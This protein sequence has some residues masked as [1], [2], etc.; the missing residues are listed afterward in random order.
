MPK[1]KH[2]ILGWARENSLL[3]IEEAA[4]KLKIKDDKKLYAVEKLSAYESGEEEPSRSLLLRM[5]RQYRQPLLVFYL[6][7]PPIIGDRGEDF[8]TLPDQFDET[9]NVNVD[10][11]IRD[12]K[13]RQSTIRETLIEADEEIKLGFIGRNKIVDGVKLVVQT[14][15]TTLNVELDDFRNQP[16]YKEAF[17]YLR[18][19]IEGIGVFVLLKGNLGYY[20][21]NIAVTAF[22]GFALADDIAPFIVINDQDSESAWA[23]TL[24]H[25]MAHLILGKTGIS[26]YDAEKRIEKF[27]NDV[28]SEFLLP[29]IE[30][31]KFNPHINDF[32]NLKSEIS[33]YAFSKKLS[34]THLAYRLYKRG[35]IKE[36][37]WRQLRNFYHTSWMEKQKRERDKNK[38]KEGGP[39]YYVIKN[40]KLG[41]LVELVQRLTYAGALT[42]T[43]A[44]MILDIKPLK[45][46]RLFQ[47]EQYV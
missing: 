11:L 9:E 25:E 41:A 1:V 29:Q 28:A 40:Y 47:P 3:S 39:D 35:F 18:Q 34:S 24:I 12:I 27:C 15:R 6:D 2:S 42:T 16:S 7:K 43:K 4:K 31:E 44:G 14:I 38:L 33:E 20:H 23:F 26:G 22:R 17:R 45:V 32:D 13:A 46:H 19:K 37:V 21:T 10:I 36:P 8:R 30:F 5:S